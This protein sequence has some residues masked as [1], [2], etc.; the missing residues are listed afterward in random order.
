MRLSAAGGEQQR[1]IRSTNPQFSQGNKSSLPWF[2]VQML[3]LKALG[4]YLKVL[5]NK[6][7]TV[8]IMRCLQVLPVEGRRVSL[9]LAAKH[10]LSAIL[11]RLKG[12]HHTAGLFGEHG[13]QQDSA[14]WVENQQNCISFDVPVRLKTNFHIFFLLANRYRRLTE[15]RNEWKTVQEH[16]RRLDRYKIMDPSA[17]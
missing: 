5:H 6:K 16:K 17:T 11:A 2:L 9:G 7:Q 10:H 14:S 13:P 15:G 8:C 1:A 3:H 12:K 4:Y